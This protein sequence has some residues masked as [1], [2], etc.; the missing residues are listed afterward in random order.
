MLADCLQNAPVR[1]LLGV[2]ESSAESFDTGRRDRREQGNAH[3]HQPVEALPPPGCQ[4][5][6]QQHAAI[7]QQVGTVVQLV[8]AN[9]R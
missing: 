3:G 4:A 5:E 1:L 6:R 2:A 7:D 8:G 9:R